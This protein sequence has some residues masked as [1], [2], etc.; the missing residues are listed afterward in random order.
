MTSDYVNPLTIRNKA[1]FDALLDA[2]A[3]Y[4]ENT[5]NVTHDLSWSEED[6]LNEARRMLDKLNAYVQK[7]AD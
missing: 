6:K 1:A 7:L 5:E 2:L 3:Q 4:V